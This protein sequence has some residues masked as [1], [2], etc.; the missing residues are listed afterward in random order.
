VQRRATKLD[1]CH[2]KYILNCLG[3]TRLNSLRLR[4]D[5]VETFMII[6]RNSKWYQSSYAL[7]GHESRDS[8]IADSSPGLAQDHR[9]LALGK[10]LARMFHCHQAV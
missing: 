3:L 1:H 10:L 2:A 4:S 5:L 7:V 6:K 8:E 9:V